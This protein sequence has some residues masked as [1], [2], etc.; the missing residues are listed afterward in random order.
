MLEAEVLV[1]PLEHLA[2]LVEPFPPLL[3]PAPPRFLPSFR[4][5]P[6]PF[7]PLHLL[8]NAG[9]NLFPDLLRFGRIEA[10]SISPSRVSCFGSFFSF[11]D[12]RFLSRW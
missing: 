2:F 12:I 10:D 7:F 3:L 11:I 5:R 1:E 4:R 6:D 9:A 8:E